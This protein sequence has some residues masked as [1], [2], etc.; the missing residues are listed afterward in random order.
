MES[1][2]TNE[3]PWNG[4]I[5]LL[6]IQPESMARDL[7]EGKTVYCDVKKSFEDGFAADSPSDTD[8]AFHDKVSSW[9]SWM[10]SQLKAKD[11]TGYEAASCA[12]DRIVS[13]SGGEIRHLPLWA[14]ARRP[15]DNKT[16]DVGV[17]S[18]I[19]EWLDT[20]NVKHSERHAVIGIEM[21]ARRV[22]LS[23]FDDWSAYVLLN[24]PIPP[25]S[26]M[27]F[28]YES[29]YLWA[30]DGEFSSSPLHDLR[31]YDDYMSD[32][33]DEM[34]IDEMMSTWYRC[35]RDEA[36]LRLTPDEI[37]VDVSEYGRIP[38]TFTKDALRKEL[39]DVSDKGRNG[40][41]LYRT[42]LKTA[43]FMYSKVHDGRRDG[44]EWLQGC[45]WKIAPE[46]V[47]KVWHSDARRIAGS[48]RFLAWNHDAS[49]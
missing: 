24:R 19:V 21:D 42:D 32:I 47:V 41:E 40:K 6:T 31:L 22:L 45:I 25:D 7:L 20:D 18:T 39:L 33:V 1:L 49:L 29:A 26:L 23:S 27:Y 37:L 3:D 11:P 28:E 30:G 38:C 48:G 9:Y 16:G 12:S 44:K 15:K 10:S 2:K 14:W 17:D 13:Y 46:D 35:L 8:G 36:Y 43:G 4:K 34:P 5:R